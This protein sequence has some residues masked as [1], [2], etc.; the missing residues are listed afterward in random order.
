[1]H[2][3]DSSWSAD[4]NLHAWGPTRDRVTDRR[5]QTGCAH[6]R[7][8]AIDHLGRVERPSRVIDLGPEQAATELRAECPP[9]RQEVIKRTHP[10]S[11]ERTPDSYGHHTRR[12]STWPPS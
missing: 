7:F 10:R 6:D 11:F 8:V 3:A 4:S 12:L 9:G 5:G 1:M 2:R